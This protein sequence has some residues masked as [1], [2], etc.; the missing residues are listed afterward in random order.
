MVAR[1]PP[2]VVLQAWLAGTRPRRIATRAGTRPKQLDQADKQLSCHVP[3]ST[4]P[5]SVWDQA[6]PWQPVARGRWTERDH[7][8]LGEARAVFK[9]LEPIAAD[10]RLHRRRL[11]SME[12]NMAC[13]GAFEKGRS[14]SGPLNYLMRKR[15]ALCAAAELQIALPWAETTRMT[16]GSLIRVR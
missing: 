8:T 15:A 3:L 6:G 1:A 2:E 16:A 11:T 9:A 5:D 14:S 4:L 13:A 12:D 7:I 10:G